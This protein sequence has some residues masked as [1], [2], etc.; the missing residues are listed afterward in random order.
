MAFRIIFASG[1]HRTP[2]P[3]KVWTA[4]DVDA[5]F[6]A[7]AE[8]GPEFIPFVVG[9]P[10]NDL[11]AVGRL[12]KTA[13]QVQG[14]GDRRVI[15]FEDGFAEFSAEAIAELRKQGRNKVS[16]KIP[17]AE[18]PERMIIRHIGFV[19][20][21]AVAELNSATF[22]EGE[23]PESEYAVFEADAMFG[24]NEYR[25][26]WI[27]SL[28][29]NMREWIIGKFGA[30]EADKVIP[31][32]EIVWLMESPSSDDPASVSASF[33]TTTTEGDMGMSDAEK[34]ELQRLQ[35]ENAALKAAATASATAARDAA[36]A[37]VFSA[38][39]NKGKVTDKVKPHLQSLAESLWPADATFGAADDPLKPLREILASMPVV[40]P[41]D[42][43]V[44]T[45]A[46]AGDQAGE[47]DVR[48]EAKKQLAADYE[49]V[50][51]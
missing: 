12:A 10:A 14:E 2:H 35:T 20:D 22:A 19:T 25:V 16:V 7:T 4:E 38:E 21:A 11:P 17:M 30:D 50:K 45:F 39:E 31:S 51:R 9:H 33:S 15:G 44:A 27:G 47:K 6:S 42:G 32:H 1:T 18:G 36:I 28:F 34:A 48:A 24:T 46:S 5:V 37:A 43:S 41:A 3:K 13:L 49:K 40:V 29:R 8:R 23:E 26:P